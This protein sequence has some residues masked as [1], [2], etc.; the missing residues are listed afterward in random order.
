M[1]ENCEIFGTVV[2]YTTVETDINNGL[3]E[4]LKILEKT[5]RPSGIFRT[6]CLFKR[7]RR[8]ENDFH[9]GP[10]P[11]LTAKASREASLGAGAKVWKTYSFNLTKGDMREIETYHPDIILLTGGT[12][13]G[14]QSV[15]STMPDAGGFKL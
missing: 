3:H 9:K 8:S 5:N 7:S 15:F 6:L 13:E 4:A 1:W 11:E 2:V 10:V 12:D 14:I